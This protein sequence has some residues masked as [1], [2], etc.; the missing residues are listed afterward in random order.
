MYHRNYGVKLKNKHRKTLATYI[1]IK[2]SI[3][4]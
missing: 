3:V 1:A 2:V 4:F